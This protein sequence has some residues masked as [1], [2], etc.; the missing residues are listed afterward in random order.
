LNK[1][2]NNSNNKYY[3]R[4]PVQWNNEFMKVALEQAELAM[5]ADEIPVGAVVVK[6]G[7]VIGR[8][9]NMNRTNWD[10]TLH[11]EIVAIRAACQALGSNRLDSCDLYVTLEPCAMCAQAISFARISRLYF[12]AYD[13]KGGGVENGARVLHSPS[14]H[15]R[16]EIYGGIYQAE[17]AELLLTFFLKKRQIY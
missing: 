13:E 11:A 5:R 1:E 10:P 15:H 8:G 4:N 12:G 6:G 3:R 9:Y 17:A 16:P 2:Y 7:Q 14:C